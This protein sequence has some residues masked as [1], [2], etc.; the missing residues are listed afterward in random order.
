MDAIASV[1]LAALAHQKE[2][3]RAWSK[4]HL[5]A[6]GPCK[7]VC[8]SRSHDSTPIRIRFGQL[9]ELQQVARYWCNQGK[10]VK[11]NKAAATDEWKL[12]TWE[13]IKHTAGAL[14]SHGIVELMA[15]RGCIAWP[16]Q[17]GAFVSH[18]RRDL[19]FP[20]KFLQLTNGST[21]FACMQQA[22]L[23]LEKF[24]RWHPSWTTW[25][26]LWV[27]IW[28]HRARVPSTKCVSVAN[29]TTKP[30]SEQGKEWS[31]SS[32]VSVQP[33]RFTGRSRVIS[34]PRSCHP[35]HLPHTTDRT[36]LSPPS[37]SLQRH[38]ITAPHS[39]LHKVA[40]WHSH[41]AL[42]HKAN[43][44]PPRHL[45]PPRSPIHPL[46][47]SSPYPAALCHTLP[48]PHHTTPPDHTRPPFSATPT[49][50]TPHAISF[51]G[52]SH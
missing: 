26:L 32:N 45:T 44:L 1:A 49:H 12:L 25:L 50:P 51:T 46:S 4:F 13:E 2:S 41:P 48:K 31:P 36:R 10:P 9:R 19:F 42:P 29:S 11:G 33:T 40:Q 8:M 14:P 43:T 38:P 37:R 30:P 20:P 52:C 24:L 18:E 3:L 22:G 7:W 47:P 5:P 16:E 23:T 17:H 35:T 15:Q 27:Q 28:L 34:P 6:S 21:I 39:I